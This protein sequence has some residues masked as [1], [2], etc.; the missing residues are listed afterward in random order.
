MHTSEKLED[1]APLNI[2]T[3]TAHTNDNVPKQFQDLDRFKVRKVVLEELKNKGLLVKEEKH[4][5]SVP[6]GE[7]SNIVIEP[8]LSYQWYV[9]TADMAK[10]PT[11]QLTKEK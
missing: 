4:P 5:I 9:K 1:F 3:D 2:F 7:R 10:K 6:R 11:Q 8:R